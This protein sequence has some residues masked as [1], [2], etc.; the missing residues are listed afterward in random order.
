[1][2]VAADCA[3]EMCGLEDQ[4][5][6]GSACQSTDG[7]ECDRAPARC[8][9]GDGGCQQF[10]REGPSTSSKMEN[11]LS[12]LCED[13]GDPSHVPW[14]G[15]SVFWFGMFWFCDALAEVCCFAV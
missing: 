9:V 11:M 3:G 7:S 1:M 8:T 5:D 12:S 13:R 6:T 4:S 10:S 2:Y 15:V 14:L